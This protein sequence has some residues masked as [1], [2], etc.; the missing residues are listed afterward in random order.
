MTSWI[1][2]S[3]HLINMIIGFINLKLWTPEPQWTKD[4]RGAV[5]LNREIKKKMK[6]ERKSKKLA[7]KQKVKNR[8][9]IMDL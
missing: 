5:A 4:F 1:I 2:I 9:E 7:E 3:C 6:K 8:F